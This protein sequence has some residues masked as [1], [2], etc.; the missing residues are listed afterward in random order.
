MHRRPCI[1]LAVLAAATA[2]AAGMARPAHAQGILQ[3]FPQPGG[4]VLLTW[5][6]VPI[7][8]DVGYNVY[9]R[10]VG[11]AVDKAVLLNPQQPIT[12]TTFTDAGPDGKGLPI[13]KPVVYFVRAVYQDAAGK[14]F[15]GSYSQQAVA[16]PQN[17]IQLP[18]L[19]QDAFMFY[20]DIDTANPGSVTLAGNEL[21]IR[22]SGPDLWD[23]F[24][25]QTFVGLPVTG[26]YQFTAQLKEKPTNVDEAQGNGWAKIGV[27]I[28]AGALNGDDMGILFASVQRDDEILFEG[29][30]IF[31]SSGVEGASRFSSPGT[32]FSDTTFPVWLRLVK[33]GTKI[34]A[35]QS[36]DDKTYTQVGD[37]QDY[38]I[39]PP[40]TY[41]GLFVT[42][43][44]DGQYAIGKFD[45]AS[46][47]LE[48]K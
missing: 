14:P 7:R 43:A 38:G 11:V 17:P 42:A 9:R 39:L 6:A 8:K 24:D 32:N 5:N 28:R 21:T 33:Q 40:I 18:G 22:A 4:A 36:F 37:T 26:D 45:A 25:G 13:G 29:R 44:R 12:S 16:T 48:P 41:V 2:L 15:E 27:E 46:V 47:K 19:P 34:S 23:R 35:F 30:K 31:G 10:D 3:A 1:H 20:W